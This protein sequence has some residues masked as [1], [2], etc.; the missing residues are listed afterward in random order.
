MGLFQWASR[1]RAGLIT[2]IGYVTAAVIAITVFVYVTF[3]WQ[4]LSDWIRVKIERA[5][6]LEISVQKSHIQFPFRLVWSGVTVRRPGP[7]A[8]VLW[9]ADRLSVGWPVGSILQR[10]LDLDFGLQGLGGEALGRVTA[11]RTVQGMKYHLEA[12][13]KGFDLGKLAAAFRWPSQDVSGAVG[14]SRLE[15]DWINEDVLQGQ[16]LLVLEAKEVALKNLETRFAR[17]NGN[18]SLKGGMGHLENFSAQGDALD[19]VGSGTLLLRPDFMESL[20]NFT[21]RVTL[22]KP[23]G[24]LVLLSA[25]AS[26][27]GHL[28]FA[29]RG[30]LRRPTPYL[31]GT[32]MGAIGADS[33]DL[34]AGQTGQPAGTGRPVEFPRRAGEPPRLPITSGGS[35][36]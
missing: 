17:I 19:L 7:V 24:P 2:V 27:D 35:R 22:R 23:T 11:R 4:Q 29:L 32:P 9:T 33:F 30:A 1:H 18:L 26:P 31:N 21:S 36:P 13:G 3:P 28:D 14:I 6:A 25:M 15:H 8:R 34:P 5:T 20:L 10:Q 16:G 12:T